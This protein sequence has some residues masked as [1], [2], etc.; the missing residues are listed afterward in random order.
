MPV[1]SHIT[2]VQAGN[3]GK[4][5]YVLVAPYTE[6]EK[7]PDTCKHD[8][9]QCAACR[10]IATSLPE[11]QSTHARLM[12]TYLVDYPRRGGRYLRL[13]RLP[14]LDLVKLELKVLWARTYKG[15]VSHQRGQ[16]GFF[17]NSLN[18]VHAGFEWQ[19]DVRSRSVRT[20]GGTLLLR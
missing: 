7:E 19:N 2:L 20:M 9:S 5:P 11:N 18:T 13:H 14:L 1:G 16:F 4:K 6:L 3:V 8:D 17:R 15:R 12:R 10:R